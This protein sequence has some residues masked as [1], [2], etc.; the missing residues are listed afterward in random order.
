MLRFALIFGA[1]AGLLAVLLGAF[2]AHGLEKRLDAKALDWIQTGV[3]YQMWHALA[4]LGA[5]ALMAARPGPGLAVAA[6]AWA[7]GI[8][9]FS[10]ALYA[11]ALTGVRTLAHIAPLG[12]TA[13]LVGWAALIWYGARVK[14]G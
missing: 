6:I 4:L 11:L 12:G 8:V 9:L 3:R 10:G 7:A 14:L 2:A 5:A 13:F 1:S